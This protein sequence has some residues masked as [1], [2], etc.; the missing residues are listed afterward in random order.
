MLAHGGTQIDQSHLFAE[1][2]LCWLNLQPLL[3]CCRGDTSHCCRLVLVYECC[4]GDYLPVVREKAE[5]LQHELL[6]VLCLVILDI[7]ELKCMSLFV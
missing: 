3:H 7:E 2:Q 1:K 4:H 5:D 6:L